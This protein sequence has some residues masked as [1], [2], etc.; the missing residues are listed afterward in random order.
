MVLYVTQQP[1]IHIQSLFIKFSDLVRINST[2]IFF[3]VTPKM[4]SPWFSDV[5]I[6][7]NCSEVRIVNISPETVFG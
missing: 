5:S 7:F 6:Q 4:S 2:Y 3:A 1:F